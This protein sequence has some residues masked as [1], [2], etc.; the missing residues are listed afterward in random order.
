MGNEKNQHQG[1]DAL[2][3]QL[4]AA[5]RQELDGDGTDRT[6]IHETQEHLL[7]LFV[8]AAQQQPGARERFGIG[9]LFAALELLEV[10][11]GIGIHPAMLLGLGQP[12]PPHLITEAQRP[13]RMSQDQAYQAV[14]TFFFL[15]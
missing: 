14:P 2:R 1:P 3:R 4:L 5:R 9:V 15:R 10:R 11:Y 13:S 6:A 12:T 8:M 7:A